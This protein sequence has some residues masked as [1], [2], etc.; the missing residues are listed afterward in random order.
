[1]KN[2][3]LWVV[4]GA[5]ILLTAVFF[6]GRSYGK[7]RK[8]KID[9]AETPAG[10][11]STPSFNPE[12]LSR[13]L[14]DAFKGWSLGSFPYEVVKEFSLLPDGDFIKVYNYWKNKFGT[15]KYPTLRQWIGD[16]WV[17]DWE[18]RSREVAQLV[19]RRMDV[20]KLP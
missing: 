2:M 16:E 15:S 14:Y 3:I 10:S 8:T 12:P 20:L 6:M 1:M 4:V 13:K 17:W 18:T 19:L 5:V 11:V 9:D 7:N